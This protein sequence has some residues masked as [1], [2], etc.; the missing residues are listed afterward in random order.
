MRGLLNPFLTT[1]PQLLGRTLRLYTLYRF[2]VSLLLFSKKDFL[3]SEGLPADGIIAVYL[4]TAATVAL[5]QLFKREFPRLFVL[6][7]LLSDFGLLCLLIDVGLY[8][9]LISFFALHAGLLLSLPWGLG[10]LALLFGSELTGEVGGKTLIASS[11]SFLL[12]SLMHFLTRQLAKSQQAAREALSTLEEVF[13]LIAKHSKQGIVVVRGE[14][15]LLTNP[16]TRRLLG[17]KGTPQRLSELPASVVACLQQ[18]DQ[19]SE[20]FQSVRESRGDQGH[21]SLYITKHTFDDIRLLFIEDETHYRKRLQEEQL[22]TLG[23]ISSAIAH[24]IRNPL[25]TILQASQ[26]L[27]E[28][29][30]GADSKCSECEKL[31]AIIERSCRRI[32]Q[33]I[34]NIYQIHSAKAA[35]REVLELTSWLRRFRHDLLEFSPQFHQIELEFCLP[36]E[37]VAVLVDP[38]HFRQ[39]LLNLCQNALEHGFNPTRPR[40]EVRLRKEKRWAAVEVADFGRGIPASLQSQIFEPF[41]TTSPKGKGLGLYLV[42]ELAQKNQALLEYAPNPEGGSIFRL[43]VELA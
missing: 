42:R 29:L 26:L 41:V 36:E 3:F 21:A 31:T 5:F 16:Q 8:V 17:L 27:R 24:E 25:G 30:R 13:P 33:T 10:L 7:H 18:H 19:V 12:F 38:S 20:C 9:L 4:A 34:N 1:D 37:P 6:L 15:V 40:L 39:M 35:K 23:R 14:E 2:A 43:K 11:A 32:D 28:R 22:A